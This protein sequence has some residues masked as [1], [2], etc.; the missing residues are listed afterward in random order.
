MNAFIQRLRRA[1]WTWRQP[2]THVPSQPTAPVSD[3]FCWR[4]SQDW[5]TFFDLTDMPGLFEGGEGQGSEATIVLFDA[6]GREL[7]RQTLL[8]PRYKRAV[9]DV[10]SLVPVDKGVGTFCIFHA[11]TPSAV[12]ALGSHLAERGYLSYRYCGGPL[13]SY[14]HGNLD[15]VSLN[16]G[17]L[18]MLGGVGLREREYRLQHQLKAEINY[19]LAIVNPARSTQSIDIH[20]LSASDNTQIKNENVK[21]S[22]RAIHLVSMGSEKLD[23]RVVLSS[24]LIMAR[25]LVFR[26]HNQTMDVFH[27]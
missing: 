6:N 20:I 9:V 19:E 17:N 18:D 10:T 7:K 3:L 21:L 25:P 8:A 12:S 15:A 26:I 2:L 11:R 22:S 27:G 14:V 16:D 1:S 5:Q 24:R 23:R 13:R 4:K